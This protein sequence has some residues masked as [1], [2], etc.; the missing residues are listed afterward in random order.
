MYDVNFAEDIIIENRYLIK[1]KKRVVI[2]ILAFGIILFF[3]MY[4][5]YYR[6]KITK[7]EADKLE[8]TYKYEESN[9]NTYKFYKDLYMSLKDNK[10]NL[11]S[12]ITKIHEC[13]PNN[14]NINS[15]YYINKKIT[16]E[17]EVLDYNLISNY[18]NNLENVYKGEII[19]PENIRY[20]IAKNKYKFF[21]NIFLKR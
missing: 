4:V 19:R 17:G 11:A 14:I 9:E 21:I 13:K 18:I 3:M 2:Y 1:N 8:K 20:E 6:F 15:I 5:P 7:H 16:L 12:L 10:M